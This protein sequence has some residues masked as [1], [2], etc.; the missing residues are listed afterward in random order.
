M[1]NFSHSRTISMKR[2]FLKL[3]ILFH[4]ILIISPSYSQE[5][6]MPS[7]V[8][9]INACDMDMDGS[10]DIIASCGYEDTLVIIFNDG[11]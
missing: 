10:I 7:F 2:K 4:I 8:H 1:I 6:T 9:A 3:L 11:Y 5:F